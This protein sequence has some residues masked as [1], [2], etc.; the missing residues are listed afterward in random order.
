GIVSFVGGGIHWT[1]V[2]CHSRWMF[3]AKYHHALTKN[4][5]QA[6]L[7]KRLGCLF[8]LPILLVFIFD[9][10]KRPVHKRKKQIR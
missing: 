9:G 8:H 7:F 6:S 2:V 10:P 5:A 1:E 4:P 3:A